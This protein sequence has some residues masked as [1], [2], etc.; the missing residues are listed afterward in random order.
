MPFEKIQRG[1]LSAG[2]GRVRATGSAAEA[3]PRSPLVQERVDGPVKAS[4]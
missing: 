1:S 4:A 2:M 3:P